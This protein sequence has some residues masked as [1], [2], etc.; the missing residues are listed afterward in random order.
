MSGGH[1]ATGRA[2]SP[3][4]AAQASIAA[5]Q[6][7]LELAIAVMHLA[8]PEL[9][10]A[11]PGPWSSPPTWYAKSVVMVAGALQITLDEYRRALDAEP[12]SH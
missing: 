12:P 1:D 2:G 10:V 7:T 8:H 5:L 9:S 6:G 3:P 4:T 11:P